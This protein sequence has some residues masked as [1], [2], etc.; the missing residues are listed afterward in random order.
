MHTEMHSCNK[1][2]THHNLLIYQDFVIGELYNEEDYLQT[3]NLP[4]G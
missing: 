3:A 4:V 1:L 2:R